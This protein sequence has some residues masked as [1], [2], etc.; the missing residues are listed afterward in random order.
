MTKRAVL[1]AKV[2]RE[3]VSPETTSG[4][5]KLGAFVPKSN[6]VDSVRAI[7]FIENLG[8]KPRRRTTA[9]PDL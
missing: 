3:I 1:A 4:K 7:K 6:I 5:E 8:L 2:S 9:F